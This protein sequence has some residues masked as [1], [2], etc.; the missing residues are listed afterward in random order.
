MTEVIV[1]LKTLA[2]IV[3]RT[4]LAELLFLGSLQR[5]IIFFT[6]ISVELLE[7]QATGDYTFLLL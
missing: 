5:T 1:S 4:W 6:F 2:L 3:I 7:S